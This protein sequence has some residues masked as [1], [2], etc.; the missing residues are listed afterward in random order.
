[1]GF[2]RSRSDICHRRYVRTVLQTVQKP[3][4]C[5]TVCSRAVNIK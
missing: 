3:V 5:S 1:M 2:N 4:V